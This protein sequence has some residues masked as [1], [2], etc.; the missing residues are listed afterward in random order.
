MKL[1]AYLIITAS[2]IAGSLASSTA[3][4]VPLAGT[5]AETLATLRLGSP[6]GA[7]DP[8]AADP[9]FQERL[10]EVRAALDVA[11]ATA[12]NPLRREQPTPTIAPP[13][14]VETAPTGEQVLR[15][16]E[17]VAPIGRTG[18]ALTPELVALLEANGV[19]YVKVTRFSLA[20]WPHAWLFALA[21]AGLL[22]GAWMVRRAGRRALLDAEAAQASGRAKAADAGTVFARLSG[23]LHTLAEELAGTGDPESRLDAIVEHVG[24]IQ[25]DDVPAFVADRPALVNR[26]GLA[27]YAELMDSF[28]AMERQ[29][30]RAWS[31]AADRHLPEAEACLHAAQPLVIQTLG[32]L[33]GQSTSM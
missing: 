16:R 23:R 21:C 30:N 27:G 13:P 12:Q 26:M 11:R 7:F 32:R 10:A 19:E 29:L 8:A 6:A 18:D 4:L 28:A 25:R 33:K 22:G 17:S 15:A 20:R 9:A 24:R 31:A 14:P 2:V 1:I 3:Y 5:P